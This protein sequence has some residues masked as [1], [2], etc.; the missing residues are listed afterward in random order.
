MSRSH[1]RSS[2]G[3]ASESFASRASSSLAASAPPGTI[4][5]VAAAS[6][7]NENS[8]WAFSKAAIADSTSACPYSSSKRSGPPGM[9]AGCGMDPVKSSDANPLSAVA[10][11]AGVATGAGGSDGGATASGAMMGIAIVEADGTS[12]GSR[13]R[14]ASTWRS[15]CC[16]SKGLDT[17]ASQPSRSARSRSNGSNVPDRRMTGI[18]AVAGLALIASQTS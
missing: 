16:E 4:A 13:A 12:R 8:G 17:I 3:V 15:S 18:R 1:P 11:S 14:R 2:E 5:A 6:S 10:R 9:L 7:T